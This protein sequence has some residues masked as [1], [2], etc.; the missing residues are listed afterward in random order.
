LTTV[1][2]HVADQ[3]VAAAELVLR[4]LETA[5]PAPQHIQLDTELIVRDSVGSP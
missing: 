3:G 1:R 5:T 2:Q 4:S